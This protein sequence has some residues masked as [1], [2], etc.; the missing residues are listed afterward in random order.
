MAGKGVPPVH[1]DAP[2]PA[3][4][5][6]AKDGSSPKLADILPKKQNL[7]EPDEEAIEMH[8]DARN[9]TNDYVKMV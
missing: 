8:L 3:F 4:V 9:L 1:V 6:M 7:A 5:D 2:G